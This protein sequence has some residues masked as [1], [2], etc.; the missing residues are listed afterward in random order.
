[1][2]LSLYFALG[3][4]SQQAARGIAVLP[5]PAALLYRLCSS[6]AHSDTVVVN[7]V[8][9]SFMLFKRRVPRQSAFRFHDDACWIQE[10]RNIVISMTMRRH[11]NETLG[12]SGV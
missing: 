11:K 8:Q 3:C 1:V 12:V 4:C 10:I 2:R 6:N 7:Y 5:S 9:F